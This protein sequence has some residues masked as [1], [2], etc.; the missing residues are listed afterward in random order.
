MNQWTKDKAKDNARLIAEK[1]NINPVL[2]NKMTLALWNEARRI[3]LNV[4]NE[5]G[6]SEAWQKMSKAD[7][8][9]ACTQ[10]IKGLLNRKKVEGFL[11]G[12]I[13]RLN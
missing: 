1:H 10:A 11:S 8:T 4:V 3:I 9:E 2:A 5:Y 13:E 6:G 7:R 12:S